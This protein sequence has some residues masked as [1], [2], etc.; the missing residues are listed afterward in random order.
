MR[1]AAQH[2]LVTTLA[3][4]CL[5]PNAARAQEPKPGEEAVA[6][7]RTVAEGLAHDRPVALWNALPASRQQSLSALLARCAAKLDAPAWRHG[8]QSVERMGLALSNKQQF[9]RGSAVA[10]SLL[11]MSSEDRSAAA[12]FR[13]APL[14]VELGRSPISD[15][16]QLGKLDIERFLQRE[17]RAVSAKLPDLS[18]ATRGS[19]AQ[20]IALRDELAETIAT[21]LETEGE[22]ALLR[23]E[24]K[25]GAKELWF[26]KSE[27]RWLPESALRDWDARIADADLRCDAFAKDGKTARWLATL[28]G[29]R[30]P[31]G[32]L[33]AANT[34]PEFDAGMSGIAEAV[35]P[36]LAQMVLDS[37][38]GGSSIGGVKLNVGSIIY[39]PSAP[40]KQAPVE[41][42][43]P[44]P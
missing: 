41:P 37:M 13:L 10:M 35:G 36:E 16:V 34:Q 31:F 29:A 7:F 38:L 12:W 28:G 39:S 23:L 3:L 24:S 27:G 1:S 26:V 9:V 43:P 15:P 20:A 33:A 2:G 6:A 18:T 4:L 14:L 25:A 40:E 44:A 17:G 5:A 32:Q 19:L 42:P 22:R 30:E 11:A 21:P 8:F